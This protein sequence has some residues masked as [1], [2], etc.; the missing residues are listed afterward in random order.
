M[1][2]LQ[3]IN[4][5]TIDEFDLI[6]NSKQEPTYTILTNLRPSIVNKYNDYDI[7]FN[8][9]SLENIPTVIHSL[10]N[11]N[12]LL[13]CYKNKTNAKDQLIVN[14]KENQSAHLRSTCQFCGL[15]PSRTTDHFMPK[16]D[17]P[18]F[19]VNHKNLIPC[20]SSCNA[21][22]G[23]YLIDIRTNTRGI[24][25]LYT[26]QLPIVQFVFVAIRYV[27]GVPIANFSLRNP[28]RIN[29]IL[30]QIIEYHFERL[31]LLERYND[32]FNTEYK[33]ILS[34]FKDPHYNG[35]RALVSRILTNDANSLFGDY[36]RN[37]YKAIIKESLANNAS[38]L[39]LF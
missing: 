11:K 16:D 24:L 8:T 35:N 28:N 26:D 30:F 39:N 2:N 33:Q 36:G 20:C 38:F 19:C 15:D 31:H 9:N 22:K 23:E 3:P 32:V 4:T 21:Y 10:K 25:N 37:Y 14:I 34:S 29:P 1:H 5:S 6:H 27:G 12:G 17:Y 7:E 13:H 18:E